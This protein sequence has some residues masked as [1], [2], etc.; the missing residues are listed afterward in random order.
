MGL[1]RRVPHKA[2]LMTGNRA[3]GHGQPEACGSP[4]QTNIQVHCHQ[5]SGSVSTIPLNL[6]LCIAGG[7]RSPKPLFCRLKQFDSAP[8]LRHIVQRPKV[9]QLTLFK[10]QCRDHLLLLKNVFW[11]SQLLP[12]IRI[13]VPL[14]VMFQCPFQAGAPG[15]HTAGQFMYLPCGEVLPE[16][17]L[18]FKSPV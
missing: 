16:P 11:T 7:A 4:R 10:R 18:T 6:V 9:L 1:V 15:R 14:P 8:N 17:H 13:F 2:I 5:Y 3:G 12:S